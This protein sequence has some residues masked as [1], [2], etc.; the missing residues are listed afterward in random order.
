MFK[1]RHAALLFLFLY[2]VGMGFAYQYDK[3]QC[4]RNGG[5]WD[6]GRCKIR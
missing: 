6:L 4:L 2:L 5:V 3:K 1:T